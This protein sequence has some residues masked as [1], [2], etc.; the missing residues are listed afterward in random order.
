[1]GY[2]VNEC[3]VAVQKETPVYIFKTFLQIDIQNLSVLGFI[4]ILLAL[5]LTLRV[6]I[7]SEMVRL[8]KSILYFVVKANNISKSLTFKSNEH[9]IPSV[10][11]AKRRHAH[12]SRVNRSLSLYL[13]K[14]CLVHRQR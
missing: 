7:N 8:T 4:D 2:L 5:N 13:A 10:F 6:D 3:M 1:M 11:L 14:I 9:Q 12:F